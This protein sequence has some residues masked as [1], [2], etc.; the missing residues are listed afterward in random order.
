LEALQTEVHEKQAIAEQ[1]RQRAD[2]LAAKLAATEKELVK[3]KTPWW[4][5]LF[6]GPSKS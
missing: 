2:E 4:R 5:R 3:A 1:Y 6:G